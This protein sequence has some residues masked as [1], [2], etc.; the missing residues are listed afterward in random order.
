MKKL[1]MLILTVL[2]NVGICQAMLVTIPK[3]AILEERF[4]DTMFTHFVESTN[5]VKE[6]AGRELS[7]LGVWIALDT[8]LE[9]YQEDLKER[10]YIAQFI[11]SASLEIIEIILKDSPEGFKALKEIIAGFEKD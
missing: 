8:A 4:Q 1:L 9:Q 3:A 2:L 7:V 6:L 5:I 11:R 10:G